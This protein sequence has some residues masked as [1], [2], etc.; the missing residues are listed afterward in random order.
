MAPLVCK[1]G[2]LA[3][4]SENCSGFMPQSSHCGQN[5]P[6]KARNYKCPAGNFDVI[7]GNSAPSAKNLSPYRQ[8]N[9]MGCTILVALASGVRVSLHI[10]HELLQF[11]RTII[12]S[13]LLQSADSVGGRAGSVREAL[14]PSSRGS[15]GDVSGQLGRRVFDT[16]VHLR[17]T[18]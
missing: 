12:A 4:A 9:A 16:E 17:A 7:Y 6:Y 8:T 18:A 3:G 10:F 14:E 5:P 2:Y 11:I 1:K 13:L 15:M